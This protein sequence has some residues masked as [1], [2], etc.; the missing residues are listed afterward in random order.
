MVHNIRV[1]F[2]TSSGKVSHCDMLEY[3]LKLHSESYRLGLHKTGNDF[4]PKTM[5][6]QIEFFEKAELLYS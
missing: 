3:F 4:H 1:G 2:Y 5:I 6:E